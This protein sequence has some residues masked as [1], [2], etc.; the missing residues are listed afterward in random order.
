MSEEKERKYKLPTGG[1][2][3]KHYPATFDLY[4]KAFNEIM[5]GWTPPKQEDNSLDGKRPIDL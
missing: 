1:L 3:H 2:L 5:D 4:E